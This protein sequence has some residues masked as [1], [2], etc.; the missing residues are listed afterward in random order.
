M[1]EVHKRRRR[2]RVGGDVRLLLSLEQQSRLENWIEFQ[3]Y[4][5]KRIEGFGKK[6]DELKKELDNA[7][8]KTEVSKRVVDNVKTVRQELEN[9]KRDLERHKVL[10]QWIEQERRI[11][12]SG[13]LK[14]VEEDNNDRDT[15]PKAA[16]R[17]STYDR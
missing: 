5:L 14:P 9:A 16:R 4:H 12:D 10:L 2:H 6:R 7:R 17:T 8:K 1:D 13:H 3:N 15:T 11:I